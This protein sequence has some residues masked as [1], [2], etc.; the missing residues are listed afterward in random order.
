LVGTDAPSL[1]PQETKT[2]DAHHAVRRHG[3][4]ILEGLVLDGVPAGTYELIAL[5]LKIAGADASPVRAVLR[6]LP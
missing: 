3:L 6:A 4:A 2:L 1:D 5:P